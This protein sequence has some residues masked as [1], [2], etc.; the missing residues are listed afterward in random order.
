MVHSRLSYLVSP[1]SL[2][3]RLTAWWVVSVPRF[4][5]ACRPGR[6]LFVSSYRLDT[7]KPARYAYQTT[8]PTKL[9]SHKILE[10][11]GSR[12]QRPLAERNGKVLLCEKAAAAVGLRPGGPQVVC[13]VGR[14]AR[15]VRV[16]RA[17]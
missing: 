17:W 10:H 9:C 3:I 5:M 1:A 7:R 2:F 6:Q 8:K 16:P 12:P 13:L 11:V 4:R 14:I 15:T